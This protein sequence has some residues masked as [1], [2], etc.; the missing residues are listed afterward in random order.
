MRFW[1]GSGSCQSVRE[2]I[3]YR[4]KWSL[5]AA[6]GV[7][8]L[9][10]AGAFAGINHSINPRCE[11]PKTAT[12]KISGPRNSPLVPFHR[13]W[14]TEPTLGDHI[15]QLIT[16]R[17]KRVAF[18][19]VP[20]QEPKRPCRRSKTPNLGA[21]AASP[22]PNALD[23][24]KSS[25]GLS[26]YPEFHKRSSPSQCS[27]SFPLE[28]PNKFHALDLPLQTMRN[29]IHPFSWGDFTVTFTSLMPPVPFPAAASY[30]RY[31]PAPPT[32][33]AIA[34]KDNC[35]VADT[36]V[37]SFIAKKLKHTRHKRKNVCS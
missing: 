35:T 28:V 17:L 18:R 6:Y 4:E 16:S 10:V 2:N 24:S 13:P 30:F 36:A 1:V 20:H 22:V 14:T 23:L 32:E 11:P 19:D 27:V 15:V 34:R 25:T 31:Y 29:G 26:V 7:P 37:G 21:N 12:S 8:N 3:L 9:F 33:S 5:C